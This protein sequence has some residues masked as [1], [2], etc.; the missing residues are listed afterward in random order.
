MADRFTIRFVWGKLMDNLLKYIPE[1]FHGVFKEIVELL[2]NFCEAHLNEDYQQLARDMA[3]KICGKDSFVNVMQGKPKS[4]ASG[5]IHALGWVNFLQDPS[6]E[7]YMSSAEL[8]KGFE[9]SQGTMT[10][11]SKIIRDV[12]NIVSMDPN[13]CLL[14]LLDD[15]PLVWMVEVNG[16]VMDI[17]TAPH[18]VQEAAYAKGLIPYIPDDKKESIPETGDDVKIIK[19]PGTQ[20]NKA[21][22]PKSAK[23]HDVNEPTLF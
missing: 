11:K 12:L 13:W 23:H 14:D 3:I 2:D 9:V 1:Q 22:K 5:I 17:R 18:E 19:F 20:N 15:N 7:P 10:T 4:W 6:M 21:S 16:F 8:A